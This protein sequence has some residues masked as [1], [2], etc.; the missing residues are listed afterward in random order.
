MQY[1][2]VFKTGVLKRSKQHSRD[3][4]LNGN[5]SKTLAFNILKCGGFIPTL[6]VGHTLP[7]GLSVKESLRLQRVN[8]SSRFFDYYMILENSFCLLV[9]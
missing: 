4:V 3:G 6:A 8:E 1:S 5:P 7:V 9:P 2:L